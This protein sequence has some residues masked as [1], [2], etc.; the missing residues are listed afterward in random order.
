[1][2]CLLHNTW[3]SICHSFNNHYIVKI[4]STTAAICKVAMFQNR[5]HHTM[6]HTH[7]FMLMLQQRLSLFK[8]H[9]HLEDTTIRQRHNAYM[10]TKNRSATT[11]CQAALTAF[12]PQSNTAPVRVRVFFSYKFKL[13]KKWTPLLCSH[14]VFQCFQSW[15][16]PLSHCSLYI[17]CY[18]VEKRDR[19]TKTKQQK[20]KKKNK[21]QQQK[22]TDRRRNLLC[23]TDRW[24]FLPVH[25]DW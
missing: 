24:P 12:N 23:V 13:A 22:Q 5:K 3:I 9:V 2:K 6:H 14:P 8:L 1:M 10:A 15:L 7:H 4:G 19:E 16:L 11:Q 18:T 17:I 20:T 25:V 21:E